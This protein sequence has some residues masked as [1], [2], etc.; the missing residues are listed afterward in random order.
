MPGFESALDPGS[1][2]KVWDLWDG[3]HALCYRKGVSGFRPP[4]DLRG[5]TDR[6][7]PTSRDTQDPFRPAS[8]GCFPSV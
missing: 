5:E 8:L 4:R 2:G 7:S 6:G 3:P 1:L